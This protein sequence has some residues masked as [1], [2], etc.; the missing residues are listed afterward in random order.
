[1]M[2]RRRTGIVPFHQQE[3]A[4]DAQL[5]Q[6]E[7]TKNF[8]IKAAER[9]QSA[10]NCLFS[11][12]PL[13]E[14]A[15]MANDWYEAC[16]QA[17]LRGNFAPIDIWIRSQSRLAAT[18]GFSPEDLLQLLQ[19]CRRSAI[20]TECWNEDMFSSVDEVMEEVF[21]SIYQNIP[22]KIAGAPEPG[23]V[24]MSN[25][26]GMPGS[27][28][29]NS[30]NDRRRFTRNRLRFPI[31]VRS[32]APTGQLQE[33]TFTE[34]VSRGGLYFLAYKRYELGQILKV[35]FPYWTEYD[36]VNSEYS[37][38]VIRLEDLPDKLWGVGIDF[39]KSLGRK[40]K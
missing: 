39:V 40:G 4:T 6:K 26:D 38:K 9:I 12:L 11:L 35:A 23:T 7:R 18:Q 34:S 36:R 15:R 1:M 30:N 37:A 21:G 22:G 27:D 17:T 31:R 13:E 19:L 25:A 3:E 32:S 33:F 5:L 2:N 10:E 28:D 24:G 29:E 14:L 20:E 8:A 16:A